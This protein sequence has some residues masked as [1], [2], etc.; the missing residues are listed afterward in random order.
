MAS[1]SSR[2]RVGWEPIPI[3]R[4]PDVV[5]PGRMMMR[6][7]PMLEICSEIFSLA[8]VP[9]ASMAMTAPTPMMIPSMVR[10]ERIL[11]TRRARRDIFSVEGMLI[12]VFSL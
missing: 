9:T 5:L 6:L 11:L 8:P 10:A 4:P 7:L 12:M 3:L 1:A 2:V